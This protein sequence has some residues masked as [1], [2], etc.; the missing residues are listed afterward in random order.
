MTKKIYRE[1]YDN[2]KK[3]LEA[4]YKDSKQDGLTTFW[5]ENGNKYSEGTYIDGRLTGKVTYWYEHG[6]KREEQSTI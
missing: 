2:G 3:R 6:Q 1:Y 5:Y 4:T